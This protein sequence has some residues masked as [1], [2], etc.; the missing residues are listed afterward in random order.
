MYLFFCIFFVISFLVAG[1]RTRNQ[2]KKSAPKP[3][4]TPKESLIDEIDLT[5][6]CLVSISPVKV[7]KKVQFK[8]PSP[9]PSTSSGITDQ[10]RHEQHVLGSESQSRS[11]KRSRHQKKHRSKHSKHRGSK[12][13]KHGRSHHMVIEALKIAQQ[14]LNSKVVVETPKVLK[15]AMVVKN[16]KVAES[17]KV[18]ETSKVVQA[19]KVTPGRRKR[20]ASIANLN[21]PND[22]EQ[23]KPARR[24]RRA[25]ST[26]SKCLLLE[27]LKP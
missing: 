7:A 6:E 15:S 22:L 21:P 23:V 27:C 18:A 17:S 8:T 14:M 10:N 25:L 3:K 4:P 5:E 13:S 11:R 2:G 12:R 16:P 9:E 26:A 20:S 24:Q 19:Q 1:R